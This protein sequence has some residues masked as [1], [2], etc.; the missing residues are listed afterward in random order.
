[1][2]SGFNSHGLLGHHVIIHVH[3]SHVQVL[4]RIVSAMRINSEGPQPEFDSRKIETGAYC[5][6]KYRLAS[7]GVRKL[8]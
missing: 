7:N 6:T 2:K 8:L 5:R 4:N 1:M 3:R